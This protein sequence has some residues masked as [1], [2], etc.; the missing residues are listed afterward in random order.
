MFWEKTKLLS[1]VLFFSQKIKQWF[2]RQDKWTVYAL[3][4]YTVYYFN[5]S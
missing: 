5:L 2:D 1:F 4:S 3:S